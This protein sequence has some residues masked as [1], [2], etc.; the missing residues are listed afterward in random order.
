[1]AILLLVLAGC[2]RNQRADDFENPSG[3]TR[4]SLLPGTIV[5][6]AAT[7]LPTE[8]P[9]PPET[10]VE[11]A[12]PTA[13]V[14][15]PP[16]PEQPSALPLPTVTPTPELPPVAP[17]EI[18]IS[19]STTLRL[20]LSGD[21]FDS[22]GQPLR[23]GIEPRRHMLGGEVNSIA[24]QWCIQLGLVNELFDLSVQLDPVTEELLVSGAIWL[25][26]GFC[27]GPGPVMDSVD[28]DLVV[29]TDAAAQISYNLRGRRSLLGIA[30]LLDSDTGAVVELRV[31]NSRPE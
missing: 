4:P 7:D 6:P 15:D 31:A 25:R 13:Q 27:E 10:I 23:F 9:P 30:G 17:R 26:E 29:P 2:G 21:G 3:V 22:T 16:A 1:M 8:L 12:T 5:A 14:V 28:V 18:E 19:G 11:L 20:A 24:D